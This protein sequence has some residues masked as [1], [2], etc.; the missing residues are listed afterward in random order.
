ML[1]VCGIGTPAPAR[2]TPRAPAHAGAAAHW[3][4]MASTRKSSP[5][6][7][8]GRARL[9]DVCKEAQHTTA[10]PVPVSLQQPC[11]HRSRESKGQIRLVWRGTERGAR[12]AQ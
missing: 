12:N 2:H 4:C 9:L 1:V 6:A 7:A 5:W 3:Q 8:M 10:V 11:A